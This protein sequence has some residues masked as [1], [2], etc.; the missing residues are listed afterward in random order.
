MENVN[1]GDFP[2][3]VPEPIPLIAPMW[4]SSIKSLTVNYS[5]T[6][7]PDVLQQ[8]VNM[9][10]RN[11][12]LSDYQPSLAVVLTMEADIAGIDADVSL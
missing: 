11:S 12:D 5:I 7:D 3:D 8:V 9:I 4:S 10:S 1:T 2:R 6:A